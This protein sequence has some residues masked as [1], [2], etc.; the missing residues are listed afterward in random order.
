[1]PAA[2]IRLKQEE[3]F[4]DVVHQAVQVLA[5]GGVVAFPTETVY[6]LAAHALNARAVDHLLQAKG[7]PKGHALA[8][9]IKGYE[10]AWDYVPD[11]SPLAGRLARRCWPGPV[12]LVVDDRHPD[13]LLNR[14]PASVFQAVVPEKTVGLR[15]PAHQLILEVLQLLAGPL[16]LTSA[17]LHGQPE[18]VTGDDV[19]RSVGDRIHLVLDDGPCR[20]GRAST[21]VQVVDSPPE[22]RLLRE[23]VVSSGTVRR[24]ASVVVAFICTGNTCR[25]PMAEHLF[26]HLL[27]RR[28]K[29]SPEE[30]EDRGVL[31]F[32][33]GVAATAGAP[34]SAEAVEVLRRQG[35]A[36]QGHE[37]QPVSDQL[38]RHAD[39]LLT[40]TQGHRHALVEHW[41]E[42]ASRTFLLCRNQD[43]AD[44]IGG[45]LDAYQRCAEQIQEC[46]RP[47]V[48][49]VAQEV[50]ALRLPEPSS[51]GE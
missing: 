34:A 14:L 5:E 32:S 19:L 42:A 28:L 3:D 18:A 24:L 9:A 51:P 47:W 45:P 12:T 4:R 38:V 6:G 37:S 27:A 49:Q 35:I 30:L 50:E 15:V 10:E 16:V 39:L 48:E 40:M 13:S 20:Y 46:L 2:V 8:L 29:C 23:G 25:S 11:L 17:N 7:R 21:V 36:L 41:P 33:A 43:V 31:V 22:V 1:M 44:P 26:R